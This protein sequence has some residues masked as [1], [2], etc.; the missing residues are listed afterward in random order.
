MAGGEDVHGPSRLIKIS[1]TAFFPQ[2]CSGGA[3]TEQEA[4]K[5]KAAHSLARQASNALKIMTLYQD[6][7]NCWGS[8]FCP[9]TVIP[10][11]SVTSNLLILGNTYAGSS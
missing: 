2:G 7:S 5:V 8:G 10:C 3:E 4:H 9:G 1:T 11:F 6:L